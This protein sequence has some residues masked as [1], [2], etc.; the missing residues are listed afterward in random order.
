MSHEVRFVGA[1]LLHRGYRFARLDQAADMH[2][3]SE[4]R[5]SS[6]VLGMRLADEFDV[7][8]GSSQPC[9]TIFD[10]ASLT[11]TPSPP[12]PPALLATQGNQ[13]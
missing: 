1:L 10:G 4:A 7:H 13:R 2:E 12:P 5:T 6:S 8:M 9:Q 3:P 11:L